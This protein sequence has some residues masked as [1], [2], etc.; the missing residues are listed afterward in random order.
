MF[1]QCTAAA[2]TLQT[3]QQFSVKQDDVARAQ[4]DALPR[5]CP[6]LEDAYVRADAFS[7]SLAIALAVSSALA[8]ALARAIVV[9]IW[10][11]TVGHVSY[12]TGIEC[13]CI[14]F[15]GLASNIALTDVLQTHIVCLHVQ[16][17]VLLPN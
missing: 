4:E 13:G 7:S 8:R 15:K 9:T 5:T 12:A 16:T 17:R 3:P 6:P 14:H 1:S 2:V 10:T 11:R